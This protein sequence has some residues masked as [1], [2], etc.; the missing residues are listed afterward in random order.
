MIHISPADISLCPN[1]SSLLSSSPHPFFQRLTLLKEGINNNTDQGIQDISMYIRSGIMFNAACC[2]L[3]WHGTHYD[4]MLCSVNKAIAMHVDMWKRSLYMY[5]VIDH[6]SYV[7]I[8]NQL[9]G[10]LNAWYVNRFVYTTALHELR[11][12]ILIIISQHVKRPCI[13]YTSTTT[14]ASD[15][16]IKKHLFI[17]RWLNLLLAKAYPWIMSNS[18]YESADNTMGDQCC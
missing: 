6:V 13:A 14:L 15:M 12:I 5:R 11:C 9:F 7:P 18:G 8:A 16:P 3:Y 1:V 4:T 10:H 2:F 17:T